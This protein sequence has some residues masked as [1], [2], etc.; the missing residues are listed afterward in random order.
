MTILVGTSGF[1]YDFWKPSFY[2]QDLKSKDMLGYYASHFRTVELNNTFYR[3][4]KT[5]VVAQW[6]AAVPE[7]F[8]FV[9]KASRRITHQAKLQGCED[10]VQFLY[11]SLAPLEG[12]L[13]AVLFQCPPTLRHD[14]QCLQGFL[15]MLPT[16][17]KAVI[18]FRHDSWFEEDVYARLRDANV[19]LC[20]GDYE[21]SGTRSIEGG[22]TPFV[23]T[24]DR[25]CVRLRDETYS[26]EDLGRWAQKI[27][28]R[29]PTTFVFFKHEE[30]AP[31]LVQR[32][33]A[34]CTS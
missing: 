7:H 26:D 11:R 10:S 17:A 16:D 3:M 13:G 30:T 34:M 14:P 25:G 20:I 19:T 6:A 27:A 24:A 29:W 28:G 31:A 12:K 21:G 18:E 4:P 32:L 9:V 8:Q 33:S 1:A 23:S 2:P 5:D 15:A 22:Q